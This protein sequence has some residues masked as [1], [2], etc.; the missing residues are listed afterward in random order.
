MIMKIG[1]FHATNIPDNLRPFYKG[2][3]NDVDIILRQKLI[4][5]LEKNTIANYQEIDFEKIFHE[6][7][8]HKDKVVK[9]KDTLSNT[10]LYYFYSGQ[11]NT[12]NTFSFIKV[13]EIE[14]RFPWTILKTNTD[15][16]GII[17]EE[18]AEYD[19]SPVTGFLT[20][21]ENKWEQKDVQKK[22]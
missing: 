13:H 5:Y 10:E 9:V 22:S 4:D 19:L 17:D 12:S 3:N 16:R 7:T 14:P 6:L 20:K 15:S 11:Q 21:K 1:L 8:K 2:K 18:I